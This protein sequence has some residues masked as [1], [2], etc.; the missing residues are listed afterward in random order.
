MDI[1]IHTQLEADRDRTHKM[2]KKR[3]LPGPPTALTLELMQ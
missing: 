2:P 3:A 1:V